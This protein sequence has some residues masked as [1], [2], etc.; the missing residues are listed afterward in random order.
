MWYLM[1]YWRQPVLCCVQ[2]AWT[3]LDDTDHFE[4]LKGAADAID[5]SAADQATLVK[6]FALPE[7]LATAK[8][9]IVDGANRIMYL[10]ELYERAEEDEDKEMYAWVWVYVVD[11]DQVHQ[12]VVVCSLDACCYSICLLF[13][14]RLLFATHTDQSPKAGPAPSTKPTPTFGKV[15]CLR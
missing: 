2:T 13:T 3:Y 7:E 14:I 4:T 11:R 10:N 15:P 9:S 12:Q 1:W 8:F 6:S 5:D